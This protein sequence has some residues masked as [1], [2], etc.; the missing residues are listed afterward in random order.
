VF[1]FT[2]RDLRHEDQIL[3]RVTRFVAQGDEWFAPQ[4]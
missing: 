3:G 2:E 1:R 4:P